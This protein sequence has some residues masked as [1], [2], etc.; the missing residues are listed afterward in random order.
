MLIAYKSYPMQLLCS[1]S[2]ASL[3]KNMQTAN[4]YSY[5]GCISLVVVICYCRNNANKMALCC[6]A[7]MKSRNY[8]KIILS[9]REFA[10]SFNEL[11]IVNTIRYYF[12]LLLR[13]ISGAPGGNR[14]TADRQVV[15]SC[16]LCISYSFRLGFST[17]D[18]ET[19]DNKKGCM[20]SEHLIT[21]II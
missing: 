18:A 11:N 13:V 5:Y 20:R 16:L 2:T 1:M 17:T 12:R 9:L 4:L 15:W 10:I 21:F 6:L 8:E 14:C 19:V 7:G 3:S